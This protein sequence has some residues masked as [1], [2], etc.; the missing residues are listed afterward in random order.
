M[1][2]MRITKE[3][4]IHIYYYPVEE[5]IRNIWAQNDKK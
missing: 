4:E 3:S 5:I 2:I 1:V